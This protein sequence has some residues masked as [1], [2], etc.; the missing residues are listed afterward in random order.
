MALRVEAESSWT[1]HQGLPVDTMQLTD[2]VSFI[3]GVKISMIH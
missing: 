2:T 1:Q 3:N